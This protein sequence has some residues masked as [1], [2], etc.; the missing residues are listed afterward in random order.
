[1]Q[2]FSSA[3]MTAVRDSLTIL[4]LV[5]YLLYLNWRLTLILMI[6][7]PLIGLLMSRVSRRLR[8][9]NRLHQ[10]MTHDLAYAVEEASN[11]HKMIK[12]YAAQAYEQSRFSAQARTLRGYAMRMVV[13]GGMNQPMTQGLATLALAVVVWVALWQ[14][15]IAPLSAGAFTAFIVGMLL[16]VSPLK[17]FVDINQPWQRGLQAA[18]SILAV[19]DEPHE[20]QALLANSTG[21]EN[22]VEVRPT[23]VQVESQARGEIRFEDISFSY[24]E[25]RPVL[26]SINLYIKPGETTVL[27]GPS[28]GGKTTLMHLIPRFLSPQHGRITFDGV[29]L[30]AI[31]LEDLRRKIAFVSQDILLF[32]DT[33]AA[34][35]A[36]GASGPLDDDRL[37]Q[38]LHAAFLTQTV[39]ALPKGVHTLIGDKGKYLSG[40]Q[41]QRLAIARAIYKD[42]PILLLDEAS[43]ALDAESERQIQQALLPLMHTRTT[44][45]IAHRLSTIEDAA[46]IILLDGGRILAQGKHADLFAS[47]PLYARLYRQQA[48][49]GRKRVA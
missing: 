27:V 37:H 45:A 39:A 19:L 23:I 13:A 30:E 22:A 26:S 40:G 49:T 28:G 32:N 44:L 7:L 5:L 14:S 25:G 10:K 47:H 33:I 3:M 31:R 41:R 34:N 16:I 8:R 36:Y 18:E 48:K 11:N 43:S 15:T 20:A 12:I 46:Q 17:R 21:A 29:A 35:V 38:S 9:L 42:A 24:A 1:L 4:G 6:T 2:I